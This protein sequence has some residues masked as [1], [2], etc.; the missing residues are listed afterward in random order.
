VGNPSGIYRVQTIP[1]RKPAD[2]V[3]DG[4]RA[5]PEFDYQG[6]SSS[7]Q[8]AIK[9]R[10]KPNTVAIDSC[11]TEGLVWDLPESSDCYILLR[12]TGLSEEDEEDKGDQ[13]LNRAIECTKVFP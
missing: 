7:I 8:W 5:L 10:E 3:I 13:T 12:D 2:L 9:K 6:H 1:E 11:E 4:E